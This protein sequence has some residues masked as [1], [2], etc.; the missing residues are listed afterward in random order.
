MADPSHGFFLIYLGKWSPTNIIEI[1][2][3]FYGTVR[4]FLDMNFHEY[5]SKS[6]LLF[7]SQW[8]DE[9]N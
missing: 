6:F 9:Q 4:T 8:P 7:I 3:L 2:W 1:V 5:N